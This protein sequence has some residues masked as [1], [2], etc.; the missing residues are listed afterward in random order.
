MSVSTERIQGNGSSGYSSISTDGQF[1][2]FVSD[3]SNL[4]LGG[5]RENNIFVHDRQT[6]VTER[7]SVS[8][9]GIVGN[10]GSVH[11]SISADGRFVVFHSQAPNLVLNDM[12]EETDI[13]VHDRETGV[14]KRVN[15]NINNNEG[16]NNSNNPTISHDG[17]FVVFESDA[18]NLVFDDTNNSKDIFIVSLEVFFGSAE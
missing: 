6:G 4:V 7:V 12:N 13:F 16:N 8:T 11:S 3:A 9:E 15:V 17:L 10:G 5:T 18:S 2:T 14:T 1:V